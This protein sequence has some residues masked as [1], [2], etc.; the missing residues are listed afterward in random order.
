MSAKSVM[1][2]YKFSTENAFL[3][4]LLELTLPKENAEN[5]IPNAMFV[6]TTKLARNANPNST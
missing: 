5:A 3:P 6:L 1:P 4:V 2:A